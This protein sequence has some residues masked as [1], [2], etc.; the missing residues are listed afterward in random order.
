MF[1][2]NRDAIASHEAQTALSSLEVNF[3]A[4]NP[5]WT[6]VEIE[7]S[8]TTCRYQYHRM[9]GLRICALNGI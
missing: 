1:Q 9:P 6:D 8:L 4:A 5:A 2:I 7:V 3:R